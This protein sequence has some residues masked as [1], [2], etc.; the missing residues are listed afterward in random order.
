MAYFRKLKNGKW[1]FTMDIGKDPLTGKRKQITRGGF[2]LKKHAQE[3]V[4]KIKLDIK[5]GR[6][7]TTVLLFKDMIPIWKEE[8]ESQIRPS[9]LSMHEEYLN[10]Q[11][12][13]IFGNKKLKDIKPAHIH[14]FVQKLQ[15]EGKAASTIVTVKSILNSIFDTAA[16]LEYISSNPVENVKAPKIKSTEKKSWTVEEATYFLTKVKERYHNWIIFYLALF[17]GMRIGEIAALR[18]EDIDQNNI[19]VK[20]TAIKADNKVEA[21]EETKTINSIRLIP[22]NETLK[23]ALIE[24]KEL[25]T[26]EWVVPGQKT[27]LHPD[28]IR[29]IYR[30]L[31]KEFDL[32]YIRFHDMRRTHVTMLIDAGVPATVVAKRVGHKNIAVT[33]NTYTD[34]YKE[35]L[36]ESSETIEKVINVVNER[37]KNEINTP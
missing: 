6:V 20:R 21:G 5:K 12:L 9:T 8:R 29:Q 13:P 4:D 7:N 11:V 30:K 15:K 31:I 27:F 26:S 36:V 17:T 35:R 28:S 22:L 25:S 2:S 37:G 24:C 16:R 32:P 10:A 3:E 1:S 14:M 19:H 23:Q 18:W 33:L 34:V